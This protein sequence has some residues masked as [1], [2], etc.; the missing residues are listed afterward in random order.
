MAE[1]GAPSN[2]NGTVMAEKLQKVVVIGA[3]EIGA[4]MAAVFLDVGVDVTIIEP[5]DKV[6]DN[7]PGRL[8]DY[9][10][11]MVAAGLASSKSHGQVSTHEMIT[12]L[13][14][15]TD[16]VIEAGPEDG[17]AKRRIFGSLRDQL[18]SETPIATTSSAIPISRIVEAPEDRRACLVAHP[19]NPPFLIRAIE[20]V[21]SPETDPAVTDR[22]MS[23]L[24]G[25]GFAPI[26]IR[27]EVEGF[28][29]NRLQSALLR[30]AYRLVDAGVVDVAGADR[31]VSEALGPR[32]ALSGPFET[33]DLN[34]PGGLR[35]HAE[36]L[37]EAYGRIGTENGEKG[38]PWPQSLV[39]KAVRQRRSVISEGRLAERVAWRRQALAQ[40]LRARREAERLWN[41]EGDRGDE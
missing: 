37:G 40:I 39:E 5:N 31:L 13:Q 21:P 8:A 11:E 3:G 19:A 2:E 10:Q 9:R 38:L 22:V 27:R 33:A 15:P 35:A 30:E 1:I 20:C 41:R 12:S 36:R 25:A 24:Q 18:G 6:R 4:S 7:I 32:W 14:Q 28:A 23:F 29:M 26:L 34:T 16:L 17:G